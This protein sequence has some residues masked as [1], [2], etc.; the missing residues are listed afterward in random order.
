MLSVATASMLCMSKPARLRRMAEPTVAAAPSGVRVR[1]R[2]HVSADEAVAL[3][4][5]GAFLGSVYRAELAARIRCGVLDRAARAA[6][7]AGRKRAVT[8]VSSSRWAGTITRA[9]EDQF[10]LGMRGLTADVADLKAAVNVLSERCALNPGVRSTAEVDHGCLASARRSG[11]RRGYRSKAERFTKTRRLAVL[12]QRLRAAEGA[13]AGGRP[14]IVVG[15]KRLW[16]QR[17]NL[18]HSDLTE[19]QW[20]QQWDAVRMFITADGET[21]KV[22][23]N[24]TIRVDP[25]GRLRI[26]V[27]VAL[28]AEFGSH[29]VIE[30]PVRF[31]YRGDEWADR[32]TARQAVR[33]DIHFDTKRGRWYLDASWRSSPKPLPSLEELRAGHVLGV[34]LNADHLACCVLDASGNLIGEP[35][36]IEVA[37]AGLTAS[38]R[39]GRMRAAIVTL[40]NLAQQHNCRAVVIENLGFNDSRTTGR[41]TLG[42]GK[43]GKRLR[44]TVSGI[45][46][47]NFRRRLIGMAA[48]RGINVI[49]VDAAYTSRWG[50]QHWIQPLRQQTSDPATV[51]SHHGAA[52]AIGRRGLG[53]AI[54]RRPAG[55]RTGQRTDA[56]KPLAR[57]SHHLSTVRRYGS[58]DPPKRPPRGV[59]VRRKTPIAGGQHRSGR[60]GAAPSPAHSPGTVE[61][62]SPSAT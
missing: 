10:Q 7:R 24:E 50:A 59:S 62:S 11:V 5:I 57:P 6:W 8:A 12:R 42:R 31:A 52:A 15:G 23:G 47:A 30:Q 25:D 40:L 14:A 21:G 16:R 54:R 53:L 1:T 9:V 35:N 2:I 37:T 22:G 4:A 44:R 51:T 39:D 46:T 26:K 48:R 36:S 61:G 34:D 27:P 3:T 32:M 13:L 45:P 19:L 55:P 33:Y 43:R 56:G 60:S 20:R 38:H 29:V 41:E 49:G 28:T 18:V 17:H 58:S